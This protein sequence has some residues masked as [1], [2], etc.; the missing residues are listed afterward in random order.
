M[1][2]GL[3]EKAEGFVEEF[4]EMFSRSTNPFAGRLTSSERAILKTYTLY[5]LDKSVIKLGK[6][7]GQPPAP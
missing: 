2:K 4:E 3:K 1:E 5:L 7:E 6:P